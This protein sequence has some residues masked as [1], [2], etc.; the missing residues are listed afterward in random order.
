VE[1]KLLAD[2]IERFLYSQNEEK[3]AVFLKRYWQL[4]PVSK[5]AEQ[6]HCGEARIHSMLHRL[7]QSLHEFLMKEGFFQ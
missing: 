3:R 5:I 7:R 2:A 1:L 6:L 4:M